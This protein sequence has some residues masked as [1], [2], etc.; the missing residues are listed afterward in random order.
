MKQLI[1]LRHAKSSWDDSGIADF[2]RP[3]NA[4]GNTDAPKL[5]GYMRQHSIVPQKVLVS[6]ALRARQTIK[7][8][9]ENH[10]AL[11]KD[12]IEVENR[13]YGA[14]LVSLLYVIG[15]QPDDIDI[16]MLAAHNPGLHQLINH[17]SK[18]RISKLPTCGLAIC[19][20]Q[21]DTW[22]QLS[23]DCGDLQLFETPKTIH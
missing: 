21:N 13:L 8:L 6:S 14:G 1:I 15:E 9:A 12:L 16:L 17:L 19:A 18:K 5:G 11:T 2:D 10:P 7:L 4:R 3:L 23:E 22:S 20:L